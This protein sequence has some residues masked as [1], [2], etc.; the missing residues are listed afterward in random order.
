MAST[1]ILLLTFAV[2]GSLTV[3]A[4]D[5]T[6]AVPPVAATGMD[7][8]GS[9]SQDLA[10][11]THSLTGVERF[12]LGSST[13]R[14]SSVGFGF[15]FSQGVDTNV[16]LTST[17]PGNSAVANF[18]G[19]VDLERVGSRSD[20][21]LHYTG[22]GWASETGSNF[23]STYHQ[24]GFSDTL[25][26]NRLR[27][28]VFD[29]TVYMPSAFY[30]FPGTGT[31]G[32][33]I[34]DNCLPNQSIL[35]PTSQL[36]NA[37]TVQISYDLNGRSSLTGSAGFSLLNLLGSGFDSRSEQFQFGYNRQM[38]DADTV[39]IAYSLGL[40]QFPGAS[41]SFATHAANLA[42]G[43]RITGRMALQASGGVQIASSYSAG[44]PA[45]IAW[46][47]QA[48]LTYQWIDTLL[49]LG[50]SHGVNA[51]AGVWMGGVGDS[52]SFSLTRPLGRTMTAGVN[53]GY[54]HNSSLFASLAVAGP[55]SVATEFLGVSISRP[56]THSINMHFGYNLQ[57]QSS[58]LPFCYGV[59]QTMCAG[60]LVRHVISA[61][62]DWRIGPFSIA[63]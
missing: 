11:D 51:G 62:V 56:V 48:G 15:N 24:F 33:N 2:V 26:L 25:E 63:R 61:G 30:G 21:T 20:M 41:S 8:A 54:A 46:N 4:Q 49:S 43:R 40:S 31:V 58:N 14:R 27:L 34:V 35:T 13:D 19:S 52:V 45:H 1:L 38:N 55:Q 36:S 37:S 28:S 22:G 16:L 32:S 3:E 23:S 29:N 9:S 42:Y 7:S 60:G 53:A 10:P 18:S 17:Q 44:V 59:N 39:G 57:H 47:V 12:T 5:D 6:H 50:Y